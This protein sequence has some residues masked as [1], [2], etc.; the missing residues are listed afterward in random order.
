MENHTLQDYKSGLSKEQLKK[1][2][3][4]RGLS[5]Y[6]IA[7]RFETDEAKVKS[8]L[9]KWGILRPGQVEWSETELRSL[10]L[11]D[12][13]TIK[14]VCDKLD[15]YRSKVQRHLA[16]YDIRKTQKQ[17]VRDHHDSDSRPAW[18]YTRKDGYENWG[19]RD[20]TVCVHRLLAVVKYGYDAL[21]GAHVHHKNGIPWDNRLSNLEVKSPRDHINEHWNEMP[22]RFRI[23]AA[24]DEKLAIALEAAG[25]NSAAS[26]IKEE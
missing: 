14:E 9:R 13:L 16:H 11:E 1:L 8:D 10:Y 7:D 5:R 25:Y 24:D 20:Y 6:K 26:A 4:D 21:D 15:T 12:G 2:Y 23:E 19:V 17:A 22:L 3:V 18:F